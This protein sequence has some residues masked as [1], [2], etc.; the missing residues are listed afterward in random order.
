MTPNQD[1]YF[2]FVRQLV[3]NLDHSDEIKLVLKRQFFPADRLNLY[4]VAQPFILNQRE[5][6]TK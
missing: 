2:L 6:F 1:I 3:E 4:P 5:V